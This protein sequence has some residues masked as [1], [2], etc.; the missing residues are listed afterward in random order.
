MVTSSFIC[1]FY[2]FVVVFILFI[3]ITHYSKKREFK[4]SIH[5][6]LIDFSGLRLIWDKIFPQIDKK[7]S[8]GR[9]AS[10]M[11]W[12]VGVYIALFGIASQRYEKRIDVIENRAGAILA[13]LSINIE[14]ISRIPS[15]QRMLC[16]YKPELLKPHSVFLSFFKKYIPHG[17]A[18]LL[19]EAIEDKKKSLE[20]V[21]L[22]KVNL[23]GANLQYGNFRSANL[24]QANFKKAKLRGANLNKADLRGADFEGAVLIL[25]DLSDS[26]WDK[27]H[28]II[29]VE[30]KDILSSKDFQKKFKNKRMFFEP[31]PYLINFKDSILMKANFQ[32][33]NLSSADFSGADLRGSNMMGAYFNYTLFHHANLQEANLLDTNINIEQ[34]LQAKTI[35]NA[36]IEPSLIDEIRKRNPHLLS[37]PVDSSWRVPKEDTTF[38][39]NYKGKVLLLPKAILY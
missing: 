35:Y 20:S 8:I 38:Y 26:S 6:M 21:S 13:Q 34:L 7:P 5:W 23:D 2:G 14:S 16:P 28:E 30:Q 37:E 11:I 29:K 33:A 31:V 17:I 25:S 4:N 18:V 1:I 19:K 10:F 32:R 22:Y 15:V 39:L 9:P 36:K 12:V 24:Q 3:F 27:H